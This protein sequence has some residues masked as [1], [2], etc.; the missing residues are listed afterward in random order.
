VDRELLEREERL[1]PRE[2]AAAVPGRA[3]AVD[4]V[5]ALQMGAGNAAVARLLQR[6]ETKTPALAGP[7][8]C[9]GPPPGSPKPPSPEEVLKKAAEELTVIGGR[10]T[11]ADRQ[12]VIAEAVKMPINALSAR[13]RAKTK[14][15]VCKDSVVDV[16][17]ELRSDHPRGWPE[18][19]TW[20]SIPGLH[21]V[22]GNRV[23]IATRGVRS[24]RAATGTARTTS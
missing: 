16:M 12:V 9:Y 14:L 6:D 4:D 10:G 1:Q 21:D 11:E 8:S 15:V 3:T 2:P 19:K 23:I 18:G 5:L 24:R 13:K 17:P 20:E 22:D 7:Y